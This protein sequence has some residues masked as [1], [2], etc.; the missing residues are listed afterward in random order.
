MVLDTHAWLWW[1]IESDRLSRRASEAIASAGAIGVSAMT[2]FEVAN[3]V[4]KGPILLE[5]GAV[6]WMRRALARP[7]V[8]AVPVSPKIALEAGQLDRTFPGDPAD[9][10]IYATARD[11][12]VPL[13]TRDAQ[14]RA[15][16]PRGTIW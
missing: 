4:A 11:A 2:C 13:I 10:M 14:I 7:G 8:V 3:L 15:Y 16:D 6:A 12:G 5:E 9:R 1:T